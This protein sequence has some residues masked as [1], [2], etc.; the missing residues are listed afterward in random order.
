MYRTCAFCD[1]K[2]AGDGGPSGVGVGRRIAFDEGRARLW[3]VCPACGRWNL[4]PLDNRLERIE[5]VAR[6]ARDGR[7]VAATAHVSLI[8]WHRYE[9]VRVGTPLRVELA[10]WRYGERLKARERER[11][12]VVIPLTIAAVGVGIAVNVA[13]GGSFGVVA[14]NIGRLADGAYVALLG[15]RRVALA[16]PPICEACGAV[17]RLRAHHLRRGR[18]TKEGHDGLALIVR[19]PRCGA[20]AALLTGPDAA[21]ALRRGLTFLNAVRSARRRA[22]VAARQVDH[23]GGAEQLIRDVARREPTLDGLAVERRL[24]LEMAV[25]EVSE[26]AELERQWKDAEELADIA[27]GVLSP[28]PEIEEHLRRLKARG[29]NIQPNG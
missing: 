24:A 13:A 15:S 12:R 1:G 8:R 26:I 25:D 9:L 16:E 2:L 4:A 18:L 23:A 22:A 14:W 27:D 7:T 3:V 5:A 28:S 17:L 19:C 6:A 29:S 10:E 20:E 21:Q 11:A